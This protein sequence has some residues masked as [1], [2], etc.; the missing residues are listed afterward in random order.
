[1]VLRPRREPRPTTRRATRR[2][3]RRHPR[4]RRLLFVTGGSGFLGH[5]IVNGPLAGEWEIV[6][7]TSQLL[8]L[9]NRESVLATIRDWR[10][11]AIVHTAYRKG[12]RVSI[13]DASAHVA[14]AA[15]ASGARL[16]HLSSDVV[17]GGR[18]EAYTEND[19]LSPVFEYG[20]DKADAESLV[21]ELNPAAVLVRTS[22]L[23]GR[24]RLSSHESMVRDAIERRS[25]ITFFTDEVRNP[26]IVDDLAAA[27]TLLAERPDVRGPLHLAGPDA[28]S[29]A[30]L[31]TTIARRHGWDESRLRFGTLAGSGLDRPAHVELDSSLAR[32][33]GLAARGPAAA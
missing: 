16:V 19:A 31:A 8:D 14:E 15:A 10:P 24:T 32:S 26:L 25:P 27:C 11:D 20:F 30:E 12:D 4:K 5:H 13:V 1:M 29:R 17:F 23:I 2:T 22:L 3:V 21:R 9:R 6:A 18:T 28:L 7:P 33:M